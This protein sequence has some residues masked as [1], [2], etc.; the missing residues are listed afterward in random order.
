VFTHDEPD[1]EDEPDDDEPDDDEDDDE[2]EPDDDEPDDEDEPDDDEP[3]DEPDDDEDDDEDEPDDDAGCPPAPPLPPPMLPPLQAAN[4]RPPASKRRGFTVER[5]RFIRRY[6]ALGDAGEALS[7]GWRRRSLA[8]L[9][10][11]GR[12]EVIVLASTAP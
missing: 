12:V 5:G 6:Y 7:T 10:R 11:P 9:S 8:C 3:D 1:D 2:D 4:T